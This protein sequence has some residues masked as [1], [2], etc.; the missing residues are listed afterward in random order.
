MKKNGKGMKNPYTIKTPQ[1]CEMLGVTRLTLYN[2]QERG[3]FTP[4]RN[5]R[6]DRVFTE[7]QA[8]EI[9]RAFSPDGQGYWH[10]K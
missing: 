2:W 9:V 7:K 1:I 8:R 10:F 4:P 6:G 3:I 5:L